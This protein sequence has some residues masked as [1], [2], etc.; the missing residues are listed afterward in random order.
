M[1]SFLIVLIV[2]VASACGTKDATPTVP[3]NDSFD[4][5]SAT[6][7]RQG[8]LMGNMNYVV[9]GL[10]KIFD[11]SGKKVLLLDNFSS[12][13][14]P[15]LRVYL[16]TTANATTFISL[17]KLKSTTGKQSYTIPGQPDFTE[18][19]FVLIWCEQFSVQFGKSETK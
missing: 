7:L 4:E 13:N 17:G 16:S 9:T 1:K 10:A 5:T 15:D 11:S 18:Y 6:L 14:G 3:I 12:N 2:L 19:K 8:T